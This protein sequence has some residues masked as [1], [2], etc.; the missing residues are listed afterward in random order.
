MPL[1]QKNYSAEDLNEL[2]ALGDVKG[3][4]KTLK[5]PDADT[6]LKAAVALGRMNGG[7]AIAALIHTLQND[8]IGSVR[9]FA[10]TSLGKIAGPEAIAPL[11]NAL[12]ESN[13]NIHQA[14][15]EA[16]GEIAERV[17]NPILF[18]PATRK[19]VP[20]LKANQDVRESVITALGKIRDP[21]MAQA[22]AAVM[23]KSYMKPEIRMATE[24]L[25]RI[26][27]PAVEPLQQILSHAEDL[28]AIAAAYALGRIAH[29]A[30]APALIQALYHRHDEVRRQSAIALGRIKALMAVPDLIAA[31]EDN[32]APVRVAVVNALGEMCAKE[33]VETL[34]SMAIYD[35]QASVRTAA[36][37]AL[38]KIEA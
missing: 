22:L 5:N 33:A 20:L 2:E 14:A 6:R 16:L 9:Y 7:D 25:I 13:H 17:R 18:E 36:E 3:M 29:P 37:A 27:K 11:T 12:R 1:F 8:P 19:L 34:Q 35:F 10:A 31:L 26:G 28:N 38:K 24:A 32:D 15:A 23:A 21:R 4:I 30:A